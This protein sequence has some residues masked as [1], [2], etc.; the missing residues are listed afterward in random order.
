[1]RILYSILFVV[2]NFGSVCASNF[3]TEWT[4]P[5]AA[6]QIRFN[7]QT[8][9][10]AVN[11]TWSASPSG[12]SGSG[13]FTQA[14]SGLVTLS[15]LNI[16]AGDVVT[17]SMEPQ[18]LRR[19]YFNTLVPDRERITDV[20]QWGAVP[21]SSMAV[22][23]F[24][25]T[26]LNISATDIPNLS[27]VQ[28]MGTMFMDCINL[29]GPA[30]I[31]QW[32]VSNVTT[33]VN[34]F[35]N[36]S[37]FNQDIGAW[38]TSNVTNMNLMF[39][40]ATS[41]NQN[42]NNWNTGNVTN[43]T[44][45]FDGASSFNG[46][47]SNWNTT[48]VTSMT[49]MFRGTPF[50]Q[51]IG[52]WNTAAVLT[53]PAMFFGATAFNQPLNNWNTSAVTN[54]SA[55]LQGATSFNQSLSNWT[56]NPSVNM[57]NLL[58]NSGM[59]CANYSATLIGWSNNPSTP[60]SRALGASGRQY[61]LL[62]VPARANLIS[63]GWTI[64]G[65]AASG[66][67]CS[68]DFITEWSFPSAATQIRF[69]ALTAGGAVNYFWTASPSGNS[70]SGSF[71]QAT[72]GAVTLSGLTIA[73]G[74][75]VTLSMEPQNLRRLYF[76][77]TSPDK[78]RIIN[79]LQWGG[80][81]WSSMQN[82]FGGC[83]NLE[84]SA[85]DVP[86]L[87][88][89]TSMS[90]MFSDCTSLTGP[91][92]INTWNTSSVTSMSFVFSNAS[93]F[94]QPLDN[95]N[96]AAVTHMTAM[97]QLAASFNQ[98]IDNWNTTAVTN[99]SFMFNQAT[100][101]NQP[102][103]IWNTAAVTNMTQ[104]FF[105][106][107]AFNQNIGAWTLNPNLTMTSMLNN[108]GMDCEN[109]SATLTGWAANNPT[110]TG[111]SLG[112]T[113]MRYGA[114]AAAARSVLTGTRG[115][116]ISGDGLFNPLPIIVPPAVNQTAN[117]SCDFFVS[118]TNP[119][120]KLININP[121]GNAF[122]FDNT[123][124][125][126]TNAFVASIPPAVDTYTPGTTG[127]YEIADGTNTFR[128][129]RRMHTVEA[130]GNYPVNGG[131]ITRVYFNAEDTTFIRTD[132][133]PTTPI[134]FSGWMKVVLDDPQAIVNS[135]NTAAP[136]LPVPSEI[137]VPIATGTEGGLRYADFLTESFSTFI[138]FA[139]TV[140]PLPVELTYF[141]VTKEG[142]KSNLDWKTASEQNNDYFDVLR[143]EDA[144][145]WTSIGT[146]QGQGSTV[147]PTTYKFTDSR[148]LAGINYYR[149]RQVD[150]DGT[151]ALL[152]IA[153]VEFDSPMVKVMFFPNPVREEL[154]ITGMP[155]ERVSLTIT[156][157]I[158]REVRTLQGIEI[159]DASFKLDMSGL[160]NGAYIITI[161]GSSH[162]SSAKVMK[163]GM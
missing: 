116:T 157:A 61:S 151:A 87:S 36:A 113:G 7:A 145:N 127:Y 41:F 159:D 110:V 70:G 25:C 79:V 75:V 121:N 98:P 76:G 135:M 31:G 45:M 136:E 89:V 18:N 85:A 150:F 26:N 138:F 20:I 117:L 68:D 21:W 78:D 29:N 4:F 34:M 93:A 125:T 84:V 58:T 72:A 123:T 154:T 156:D 143:S 101:F 10:G 46:Q 51:P 24:S 59:D 6:T 102:I 11:Y 56:L 122:D 132:P 147:W 14:G 66:N 126:I 109:Y 149:L 71:T 124:V 107:S 52:N 90:G 64:S 160:T 43:M 19:I 49:A 53:M 57:S 131:V 112:A 111:R 86:N 108:S 38:N 155:N 3:I 104:M 118:P 129:S 73:A 152:P 67:Y 80:V 137:V 63:K 54:M 77:F 12:N 60:D 139:S 88:T 42:L 142:D 23:F 158:G 144:L 105:G 91:A 163:Q 83:S 22:A 140:I 30:N 119:T 153:S 47:M 65:D 55:M 27:N 128:I 17:L 40:A 148:P 100:S 15:G 130:P 114:D 37:A 44:Q 39:S 97:F 13:S 74:D 2:F 48:N 95:W 106:A 141:S 146:V 115:W 82:A 5:L 99:M 120:Q 161:Y 94:N 16:A 134:N 28:D 62:A 1:M 33:M 162:F 69:N 35:R 32:D 81:P 92:N 9:G 50:N 96:T 133:S 103:S 8:A